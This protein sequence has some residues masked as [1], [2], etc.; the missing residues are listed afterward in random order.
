MVP[1][2]ATHHILCFLNFIT[3]CFIHATICFG[4]IMHNIT[5]V[6]ERPYKR[7]A[8]C[9][10][11]LSWKFIG[12][13]SEEPNAFTNLARLL[14]YVSIV[15]EFF[16]KTH[17]IYFRTVIWVTSILLKYMGEW[18]SFAHF[19]EKITSCVWKPSQKCMA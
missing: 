10:K 7:L 9:N 14:C 8:C 4:F 18:S 19:H 12:L 13:I 6:K 17:P 3:I 15:I 11:S 2:R 1:N 5:L 16:I